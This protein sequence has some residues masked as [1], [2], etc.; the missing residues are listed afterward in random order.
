MFLPKEELDNII[1]NVRNKRSKWGAK[2]VHLVND[3][4]E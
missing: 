3:S 1:D 4:L 2:A